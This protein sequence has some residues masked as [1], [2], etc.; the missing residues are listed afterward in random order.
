MEEVQTEF[1]IYV[2]AFKTLEPCGHSWVLCVLRPAARTPRDPK[3]WRGTDGREGTRV[4]A[5]R[6]H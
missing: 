4:G 5:A 6:Q 3:G 1:L 2:D